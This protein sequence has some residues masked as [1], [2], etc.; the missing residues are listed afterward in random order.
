MSGIK[1]IRL[2]TVDMVGVGNTNIEK[3][4]VL[5]YNDGATDQN[6]L[7]NCFDPSITDKT[8]LGIISAFKYDKEVR[9]LEIVERKTDVTR[10]DNTFITV[11][12]N[13]NEIKDILEDLLCDVRIDQIL[14]I[15][16]NNDPTISPPGD[17][18]SDENDTISLQIVASDPDTNDTLTYSAS[19]L[20][21]GLSINETTGLISGTLS[22]S[23][24]GQ[25]TVTISVSDGS[26]SVSI[27]FTWT[28][29]NV[30]RW[31]VITTPGNQTSDE[32][33]TIS[34]QIVASDPDTNDTLTYS[35]STLPDGLS[36]NSNTGL[37]SGTLSSIGTTSTTVYVSDGSLTASSS[38][39]WYVLLDVSWQDNDTVTITDETVNSITYNDNFIDTQVSNQNNLFVC[40]GALSNTL[41]TTTDEFDVKFHIEKLTGAVDLYIGIISND[42][43]TTDVNNVEPFYIAENAYLLNVSDGKFV[44]PNSNN[45]G[46]TEMT[47]TAESS[48]KNNDIINITLIDGDLIFTLNDDGDK[49]YIWPSTDIN[50]TKTYRLIV[51][52]NAG[53]N[54]N[55]SSNELYTSR[56]VSDVSNFN[57]G[58]NG[59]VNISES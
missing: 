1:R 53:N 32:N 35:S 11:Q 31:P 54:G 4:I 49:S 34:L 51:C 38:F 19:N 41:F 22:Y 23:S 10:I 9:D 43:T 45:D 47:T 21:D 24:A 28:V 33:D 12:N 57:T 30:N 14:S 36:I 37:I 8:N 29:S 25:N 17:Q 55:N 15:F 48:P 7:S 40:D 27:V 3:D 59:T 13:F 20:P 2:N 52:Y 16:G 44:K 39:D 56:G 58:G 50:S 18:T 6:L 42:F 5:M 46:V 26:S